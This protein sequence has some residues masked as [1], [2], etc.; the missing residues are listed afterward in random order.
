MET[1]QIQ[2]PESWSEI[3]IE[4]FQEL[5]T[6]NSENTISNSINIIACLT[7]SDTEIIKRMSSDDL[8]N[9][10]ELL[11]WS[12]ELPPTE[13]KHTIE[14]DGITYSLVPDLNKLTVGEWIDIDGYLENFTENIHNVM[15]I[16]YRPLISSI[17]DRTRIV[18][19]YNANDSLEIAKIFKTKMNIADVY[20][21]S[22]FFFL[23][24]I[25]FTKN[26]TDYLTL[27]IQEMENQ[28]K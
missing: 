2:I 18:K 11:A 3:S 23:I 25:E 26:L 7:E 19:E 5:S 27:E 9:V 21:T 1:T 8:K 14:I 28:K 24:G 4:K 6:F 20:G 12:K 17:N 10:T 13:F 15:A 16:L 22:I